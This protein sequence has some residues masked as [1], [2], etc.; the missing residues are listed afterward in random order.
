MKWIYDLSH[1]ELKDGLMDLGLK[2]FAADQVS[3]WLYGKNVPEIASWSNVSKANRQLLAKHF[4]TRHPTVLQENRDD[5][6]TTKFLLELTGKQRIEAVF[7][8]EKHHYTFCISAQVGCALK[9]AFC[10]TGQMGF[11]RNLS[12]GEIL[13]QV[14]LLRKELEDYGGKINIVLMGMG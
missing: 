10:A 9:C 5:E 1:E 13:A 7:M 2:G 3:Q 14:L 12:S 11:K 8:P 6:G 4:D